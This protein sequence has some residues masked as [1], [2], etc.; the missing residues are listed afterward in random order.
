MRLPCVD[1]SDIDYT[2]YHSSCRLCWVWRLW[3]CDCYAFGLSFVV[4]S[5]VMN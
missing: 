1:C 2:H 3:I 4:V 5:Y